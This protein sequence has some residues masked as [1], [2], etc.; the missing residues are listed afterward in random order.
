MLAEYHRISSSDDTRGQLRVDA[1][2]LHS[3]RNKVWIYLAK[4]KETFISHSP[5]RSLAMV[6]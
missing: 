3:G 6:E 1:L 5:P 4:K 2:N